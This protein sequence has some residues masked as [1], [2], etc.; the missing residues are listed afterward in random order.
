MTVRLFDSNRYPR[1]RIIDRSANPQ[2]AVRPTISRCRAGKN[3][4]CDYLSR[5][6][7]PVVVALAGIKV[8]KWNSVSLYGAGD[9]DFSIQAEQRRRSVGGERR[10]ALA[11]TRRNVTKIAVFL[12]AKTAGFPPGERLVVP[13]A[14]SVQANV[15]ADRAHVPD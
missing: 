5:L 13:E 7:S 8:A 11:P 9:F 10:P 15:A 1:E 2:L 4:L 3:N 12:D 14:A 6:Q